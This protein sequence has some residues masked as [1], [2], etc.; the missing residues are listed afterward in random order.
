MERYGFAGPFDHHDSYCIAFE[1]AA[2]EAARPVAG[3]ALRQ[4][5]HYNPA[6][7]PHL[8]QPATPDR[9]IDD[10]LC[11]RAADAG[12]A[13]TNLMLPLGADG[14]ALRAAI[15]GLEAFG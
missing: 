13:E 12:A 1:D 4:F 10:A 8:A 5:D 14:P 11:P 3:P 2:F 6:D 15:S 9:R 7:G